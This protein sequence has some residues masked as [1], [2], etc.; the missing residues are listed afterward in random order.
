MDGRGCREELG[1]VEG[2]ENIIK[3]H[4]VGKKLLSIKERKK[5]KK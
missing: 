4:F 3:I 1:K 5:N 2:R